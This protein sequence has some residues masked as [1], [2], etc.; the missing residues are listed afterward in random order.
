[1]AS[2]RNLVAEDQGV[3]WRVEFEY[4]LDNQETWHTYTASF[5]G[6]LN[7]MDS[8]TV[9][10]YMINLALELARIDGIDI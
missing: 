8:D 3:N 7:K 9:T 2:L 6:D 10:P 1:M 4:S 5:P